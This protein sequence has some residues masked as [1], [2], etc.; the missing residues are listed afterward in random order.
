MKKDA[1]GHM[2]GSTSAAQGVSFL[3]PFVVVL[4]ITL[5]S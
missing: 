2:G 5:R 3:G 1:L 4:L